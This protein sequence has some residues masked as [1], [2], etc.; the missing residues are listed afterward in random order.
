MFAIFH[1]FWGVAASLC[2]LCLG[3]DLT[4]ELSNLST[5][6]FC[7]LCVWSLLAAKNRP[8]KLARVNCLVKWHSE[9]AQNTEKVT[10]VWL[11]VRLSVAAWSSASQ[12]RVRKKCPEKICC[13]WMLPVSFDFEEICHCTWVS[14]NPSKHRTFRIKSSFQKIQTLINKF[15]H[16]EIKL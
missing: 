7:L 11:C 16:Q 15:T 13:T 1:I 5:C 14:K 6:L 10:I 3:K 9:P 12:L 4:V 8:P 2:V